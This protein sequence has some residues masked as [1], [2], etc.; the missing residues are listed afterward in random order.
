M[1]ERNDHYKDHEVIPLDYVIGSIFFIKKKDEVVEV[2]I[3][4]MWFLA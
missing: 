4:S 1:Y 3:V 2:T